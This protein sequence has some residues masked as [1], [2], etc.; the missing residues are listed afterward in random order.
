MPMG[1]SMNEE[2]VSTSL[3]VNVDWL[4][5]GDDGFH[6]LYGVPPERY[7]AREA[8]RNHASLPYVSWMAR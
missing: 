3:S 1:L 2:L 7:T 5:H 8:C 4:V 6:G